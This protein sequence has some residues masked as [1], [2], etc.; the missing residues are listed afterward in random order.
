[1]HIPH[2]KGQVSAS[3]YSGWIELTQV[4][5]QIERPI[6]ASPYSN[7]K[8]RPQQLNFSAIN[9]MKR[10]DASSSTLFS[11]IC[12]Q[13]SLP[14]IEIHI[15]HGSDQPTPYLKY[16]LYNSLLSHIDTQISYGAYPNELISLY[17]TKIITTYQGQN[18]QQQARAPIVSGYNLTTAEVL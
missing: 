6:A 12:S 15:C 3:G 9:I 10:I 8:M 14:L 17:F 5:F 1:M 18:A 2:T 11:H 4:Y 7:V 13:Q 16:Q